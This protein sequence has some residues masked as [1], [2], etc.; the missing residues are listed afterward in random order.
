M[1][2]LN[3]ASQQGITDNLGNENSV[4]VISNANMENVSINIGEIP[5]P[6]AENPILNSSNSPRKSP[7]ILKRGEVLNDNGDIS[8][9]KISFNNKEKWPSLAN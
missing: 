6:V 3:M 5:I 4:N 8:N 2:K 9:A 7:R 1:S